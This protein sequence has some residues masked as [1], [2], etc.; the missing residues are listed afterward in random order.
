M[1]SNQTIAL[2]GLTLSDIDERR[3]R[4]VLR[5]RDLA[6]RESV[7]AAIVPSVSLAAL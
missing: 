7:L 5:V 1:T 6:V 2:P 4:I 3:N